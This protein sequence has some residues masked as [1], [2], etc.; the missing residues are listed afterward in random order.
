MLDYVIRN[1]TVID[2]TGAPGFTADVGISGGRITAVG[3]IA[4]QANQE[5]DASGLMVMPGVIDPHTH[6][7]AQLH[8]DPTASPA[9]WHG[10]TT[11][12]TGNC[13]F[14]LAPA[15]PEDVPWLL[16]MLSRVEGMS[17]DALTSGVSFAGAAVIVPIILFNLL[18]ARHSKALFIAIDHLSDPHEKDPGED[19]GNLP[20]PDAPTRDSGGPAKPTPKLE[21]E[22]ASH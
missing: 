14:T 19:G 16:Q 5:L 22:L 15:K 11:L 20:K 18:F 3:S 7:D 10:V 17:A 13:G 2:G 8:W 4:E 9:S 21:P 1:A 6:Y 12:L